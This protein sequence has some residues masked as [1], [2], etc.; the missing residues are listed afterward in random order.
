MA[1]CL[2]PGVRNVHLGEDV[3]WDFAFTPDGR[4]GCA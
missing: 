2:R 1:D 4:G 3:P